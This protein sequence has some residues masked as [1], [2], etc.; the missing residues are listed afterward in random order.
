M[1]AAK[2]ASAK[3]TVEI[4]S[5]DSH[6]AACG[7]ALAAAAHEL[8]TPLAIM[9][10]YLNLLIA[11]KLGNAAMKIAKIDLTDK[12]HGDA[13][14]VGEDGTG[15]AVDDAYLRKHNPHAGGYLVVYADGYV[16][17]SPAKAFEE[18]YTRI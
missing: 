17:F 9:G 18:G 8:K 5:N 11:Q 10:G 4:L 12:R 2:P 13:T 14:L 16:S 6:C 3:P 1:P 15:I 7:E